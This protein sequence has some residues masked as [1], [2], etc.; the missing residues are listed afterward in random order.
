MTE[1]FEVNLTSASILCKKSCSSDSASFF[2]S[3]VG[4]QAYACIPCKHAFG[5]W[6]VY[7][8]KYYD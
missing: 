3:I 2:A 7:G 1:H 5:I 8:H 6:G 4:P